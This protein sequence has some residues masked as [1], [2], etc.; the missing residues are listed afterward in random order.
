[1]P[2]LPRKLIKVKAKNSNDFRRHTAPGNQRAKNNSPL[3]VIRC[4][5]HRELLTEMRAQHFKTQLVPHNLV[6]GIQFLSCRK[7]TPEASSGSSSSAQI[8]P[9]V[10]PSR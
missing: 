8:N 4:L 9:W 3:T 5:R 2:V 6:A 1:M 10:S 7:K